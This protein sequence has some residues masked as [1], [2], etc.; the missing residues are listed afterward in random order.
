MPFLKKNQKLQIRK[1]SNSKSCPFIE[2]KWAKCH[3]WR[4]IWSNS[5]ILGKWFNCIYFRLKDLYHFFAY[6]LC[7][8]WDIMTLMLWK[9]EHRSSK[10]EIKEKCLQCIEKFVMKYFFTNKAFTNQNFH[11]PVIWIFW[12][13]IFMPIKEYYWYLI[14]FVKFNYLM[15]QIQSN[16]Y[17]TLLLT[18]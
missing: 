14:F 15:D 17:F 7:D 2:A 9:W 12:K 4:T 5:F 18:Q 8:L 10:Q 16:E 1:D 6:Q 3:S 11:F 13:R